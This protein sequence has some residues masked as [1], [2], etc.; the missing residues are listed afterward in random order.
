M[1]FKENP[2]Q[3]YDCLKSHKYFDTKT[4]HKSYFHFHSKVKWMYHKVI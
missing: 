1:G 4:T 2:I 3:L